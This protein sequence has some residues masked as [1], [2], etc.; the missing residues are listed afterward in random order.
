MTGSGPSSRRWTSRRRTIGLRVLLY[1]ALRAGGALFMLVLGALV[2]FLL[3]HAVPGDAAIA[4][5]GEQASPEAVAA[6]RHARGLDQPL[7]VQFLRWAGGAL[8]GDFGMS[9]SLAGGF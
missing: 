2:V 4:A 8:R 3:M 5:L 7:I 1:L 6:F 9:I